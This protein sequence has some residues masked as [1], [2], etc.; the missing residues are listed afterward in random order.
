MKRTADKIDW[1]RVRAEL[2][3]TIQEAREENVTLVHYNPSNG[4]AWRVA[5]DGTIEPYK[6]VDET[7]WDRVNALTE[8][9]IEAMAAADDSLP[10]DWLDQAVIVQHPDQK[11]LNE[12]K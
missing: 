4:E 6:M 8:A 12:K 9:E 3:D 5:P 2:A 10:A 11:A 1:D 7:D